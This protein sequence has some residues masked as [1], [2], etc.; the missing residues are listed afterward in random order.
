MTHTVLKVKVVNLYSASL[1]IHTSNVL[2]V[3]NQ[4]RQS[5][6]RRMQSANT[7]RPARQP[8]PAVLRSPP[9]V[10]HINE[11]PLI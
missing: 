5:H 8:Q 4:S 2:F 3:T 6:S 7:D 11:L 10:T 1:C 9:S